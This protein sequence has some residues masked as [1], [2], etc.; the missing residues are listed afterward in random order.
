MIVRS[1]RIN[2]KWTVISL[3]TIVVLFLYGCRRD[4]EIGRL[5]MNEGVVQSVRPTTDNPVRRTE[6]SP[7]A[8]IEPTKV[9]VT[10]MPTPTRAVP[11]TTA[12]YYTVTAGD[13]LSRIA[14]LY[15]TTIESLMQLNNLSNANQL[16]A[17][18]QL[19][20]SYDAQYIGPSELLVPDSELILGPGYADFDL[21]AFVS[22]H[23]GYLNA[24]VEP[25]MG[26]TMRGSE[27]IDLVTKQYS[28][29]PRALLTMLELEGGWVT[30]PN[31]AGY[32]LTYPMGY[33]GPEYWQGLYHQL[34]LAADALNT[35]F[36]GW[37]YD[38][39]WL[40]QTADGVYIR[41]SE[42]LNAGT[43]GIQYALAKSSSNYAE[44]IELLPRYTEIYDQLF[45]SAFDFAVEPLIPKEAENIQLELPWSKGETW[46]LSGG[47]H[48]G[49]GTLGALSALDF[50]TGE[51]NIGCQM[52]QNWVTAAVDGTVVMS[53]DGMVLQDVDGDNFVG[54]GWVIQYMH[55]SSLDRVEQGAHL[56]NGD[57]IGHPSCE[58]GVSYASHLHFAR[59]YNGLWIAV[60]DQRWPIN[61]SGWAANPGS[62]A[63]EGSLIKGDQVRTAC[64]CWEDVNAILHE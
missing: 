21:N 27:I 12:V 9:I 53:Y 2:I 14:M 49:W 43:A 8:E 46:Y 5:N 40:V 42:Q 64:E 33:I 61:L 13:T 20:V 54:S 35:G 59:R 32:Q 45:G 30:N 1:R 44:W 34:I 16:Q 56:L 57:V 18:Q 50:V 51:R 31:P 17:G 62:Q 25:V 19:Q 4:V 15:G 22:S 37:W 10:L 60:D 11:D 48:P 63:Y 58:G 52:S 26:V 55:I 39:V 24:Y 28:V 3:F 6:T 38:D 36:Y 7:D 47:P 41:Y 29:G 23:N